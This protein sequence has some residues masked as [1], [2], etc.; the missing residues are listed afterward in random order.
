MASIDLR[1]ISLSYEFISSSSMNN[2]A[3]IHKISQSLA[4]YYV[5]RAAHGG[6]FITPLVAYLLLKYLSIPYMYK[7][8]FV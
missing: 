8:I 3:S 4:V 6:L 1:N 2:N 5:P 7:Y